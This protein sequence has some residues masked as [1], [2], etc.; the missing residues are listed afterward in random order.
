MQFFGCEALIYTEFFR[1]K[2]IFYGSL[3]GVRRKLKSSSW[4]YAIAHYKNVRA[5]LTVLVVLLVIVNCKDD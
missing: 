3:L 1:S 5:L 2:P 4:G